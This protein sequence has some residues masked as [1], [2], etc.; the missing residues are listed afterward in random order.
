MH[1]EQNRLAPIKRGMNISEQINPPLLGAPGTI[2]FYVTLDT[3]KKLLPQIKLQLV[4]WALKINDGRQSK[5]A[6]FLGMNRNTLA[7]ILQGDQ[8]H[9]TK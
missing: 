8:W 7:K 6:K 3:S 4:R 1:E 2:S 9:N 5:A